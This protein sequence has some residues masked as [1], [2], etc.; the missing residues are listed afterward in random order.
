MSFFGGL[1][2]GIGAISTYIAGRNQTRAQQTYYNQVSFARQRSIENASALNIQTT[3]S[4]LK[5]A[6]LR[7]Q[8]L[9]INASNSFANAINE[10]NT[11]TKILNQG[12]KLA[13]FKVGEAKVAFANAG[14]SNS[15]SA[16][17]VVDNIATATFR[18]VDNQYR[19]SVNRVSGFLNE[20]A[21]LNFAASMEK[22]SAE[23][24]S[25]LRAE[26]IRVGLGA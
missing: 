18:D 2:Q 12:N 24:N 6:E 14:V 17:V 7:A 25:K 3:E 11:A 16:A 10:S 15:G 9:G 26:S 20:Q 22:Y 19:D 23:A 1:A 5:V 13:A 21:Q 8:A 4:E